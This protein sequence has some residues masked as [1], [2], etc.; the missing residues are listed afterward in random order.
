MIRAEQAVSKWSKAAK[1]RNFILI[2]D[3]S[4]RRSL[5]LIPADH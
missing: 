1:K 3:S 5:T 4:V 2:K